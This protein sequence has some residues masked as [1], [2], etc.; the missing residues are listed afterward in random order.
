[1]FGF[2]LSVKSGLIINFNLVHA[3]VFAAAVGHSPQ[4][5]TFTKDL[6]V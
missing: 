5:G 1:M 6:A 4:F 3:V 2:L